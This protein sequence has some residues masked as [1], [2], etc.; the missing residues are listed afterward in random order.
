MPP[1]WLT[2]VAVTALVVAGACAAL[3]VVDIL[4][5]YRQPMVVMEFVWPITTL[6]F[7]PLGLL[8]Y[9][10]W[11]RPQTARWE[12]EHGAAPERPFP[13][14]VAI[15]VS[16]CGGGC[17]IGDV[18]GGWLVFLLA[19]QIAGV[20]LFAEY[21]VDFAIAFALGIAFQYFAI[22]PMRGLGLRDGIVASVQ[23]DSASLAAFEIGMFGWM[24]VVQFVFFA[25]PHLTPDHASYWFM[26]QVG[27]ILGFATAYP[28][29]WWLL[30]RGIKEAM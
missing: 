22:A 25:Q 14:T 10:R 28:V 3:V 18:I 17:T 2:V 5:G 7:G 4:R 24:A 6:Y 29:N 23:A 19:L 21:A 8:A 30:R 1:A 15:G 27:M 9:A 11:G 12:K 13:A 20:A 26:M 16:H